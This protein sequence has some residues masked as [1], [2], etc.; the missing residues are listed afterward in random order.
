MSLEFCCSRAEL[1]VKIV[2]TH[3][4]VMQ[5]NITH[6]IYWYKQ[7]NKQTNKNRDGGNE[8]MD[9]QKGKNLTHL[10]DYIWQLWT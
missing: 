9:S 5:T 8:D 3:K 1:E 2:E 10:S 4:Q 7:T 6:I